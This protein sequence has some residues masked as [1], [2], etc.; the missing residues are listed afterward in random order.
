MIRLRSLLLPLSCGVVSLVLLGCSDDQSSAQRSGVTRSQQK[1]ADDLREEEENRPPHVGM[2]KPEAVQRYGQP[3]NV[4][5]T[6]A[7]ERWM[8]FLNEGEVV[9]KSLIPFYIPPRP[10]FGFL[11]FGA[12]GRVKEFRWDQVSER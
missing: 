5:L 11:I 12:N 10:R 6:D 3:K 4:V 9:G 7:G 1:S 2:S 8:Y